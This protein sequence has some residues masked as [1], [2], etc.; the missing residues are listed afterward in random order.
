MFKSKSFDLNNEEITRQSEKLYQPRKI[1]WLKYIIQPAAIAFV[2]LLIICNVDFSSEPAQKS[3][4]FKD[5]KI[6][7]TISS[8]VK[9]D[10]NK[11]PFS[12][13]AEWCKTQCSKPESLNCNHNFSQLVLKHAKN[14][15]DCNDHFTLRL[16]NYHF[17]GAVIRNNTF[18]GAYRLQSLILNNC[19]LKYITDDA[20]DQ[21]SLRSLL[22]IELTNTRLKNISNKA[23]RGLNK[24]SNFTLINRRKS[25]R[26][27]EFMLPLANT[28][29]SAK[30]HQQY[31]HHRIYKPEYFFGKADYQRLKVLDLSGTN[32]GES[33]EANSFEN[34]P[35]LEYLI[36]AGCRLS[37]ISFDLNIGFGALRYLDLS[38]N[39]LAELS[40]QLIFNSIQSGITLK[41]AD[42]NWECSCTTLDTLNSSNIKSCFELIRKTRN[43]ISTELPDSYET[44]DK[45]ESTSTTERRTAAIKTTKSTST[46][47]TTTPAPTTRN[48]S[49]TELDLR[50]TESIDD[51]HSPL[52]DRII[53]VNAAKETISNTTVY[54]DAL[55]KI[56][57]DS[58][59]AVHIT[60]SQLDS[61][62]WSIIYFSNAK[63][64]G[65]ISNNDAFQILDDTTVK[66]NYLSCATAYVFCLLIEE[67][68]TS[69]FNCRSHQTMACSGKQ[70]WFEANS[71]LIVGLGIVGVLLC[72]TL[73]L[74]VMYGVLWIHPTW[75]CGSKRLQR[76]S[77]GSSIM[78]LLP[79]S[80]DTELYNTIGYPKSESNKNEYAAYYRHLEQA[81]LYQGESNKYNI[82][83]LERAPSVPPFGEKNKISTN[84]N[85]YTYEC[86]E[87][88][89]ELY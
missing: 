86:F 84:P 58:D 26:C 10:L 62:F 15:T 6:S 61:Q 66:I 83:P 41:L 56:E 35:A 78:V 47:S 42:N 24:L 18:D 12:Q 68:T 21:S 3:Q 28:L 79:S 85:S 59:S 29:C 27:K 34:M 31:T 30:I 43:L 54:Y 7:R 5:F 71:S 11:L 38:G 33:A 50:T 19:V 4:D 64:T 48:T 77:P 25:L 76:P 32:I 9:I 82:P 52:F 55:I 57:D 13:Y 40:S 17:P 53:C 2:L 8:H 14:K 20:F 81:K 69:P 23:F 60:L 37:S 87:L 89:E 75:L 80:F 44:T 70:M 1:R 16:K 72:V 74:F 51:E 22:T 49:T 63:D 39:M 65:Q 46:L 73:G 67:N 88:Y 45:T 36:L